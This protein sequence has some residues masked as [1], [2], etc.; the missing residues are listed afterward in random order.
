MKIGKASVYKPSRMEVKLISAL[1]S[2]S[3]AGWIVYRSLAYCFNI[4]S[5]IRWPCWTAALESELYPPNA[6]DVYHTCDFG[7]SWDGCAGSLMTCMFHVHLLRCNYEVFVLLAPLLD[8]EGVGA[9][10]EEVLHIL[11]CGL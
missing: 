9:N 8:V 5:V 11:E 7:V 4:S 2:V 1:A 3:E 6:R 10:E